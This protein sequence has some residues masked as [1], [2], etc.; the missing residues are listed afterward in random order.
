MKKI[1]N[2][3]K[4]SKGGELDRR[5][6]RRSRAGALEG[7]ESRMFNA[8]QRY[9]RIKK[10]ALQRIND[11]KKNRD[12][13]FRK[14]KYEHRKCGRH[15]RKIKKRTVGREA[16]GKAEN[17]VTSRKKVKESITKDRRNEIKHKRKRK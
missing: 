6:G 7:K 12:R 14:K 3:L 2:N 5:D 16:F 10:V 11:L 9:R 4:K 17:D 13:A 15:G 1:T 8:L